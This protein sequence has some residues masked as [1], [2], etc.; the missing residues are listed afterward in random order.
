LCYVYNGTDFLTRKEIMAMEDRKAEALKE[1]E[2]IIQKLSEMHLQHSTDPKTL[3]SAGLH[4]FDSKNKNFV[5][6]SNLQTE[7]FTICYML[8]EPWT[9]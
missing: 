2:A 3:C 1:K 7:L 9:Q 6:L 8:N 5:N 4:S